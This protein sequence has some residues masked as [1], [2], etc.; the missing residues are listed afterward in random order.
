MA[1]INIG[2]ALVGRLG[3]A[4]ARTN[5]GRWTVHDA[6]QFAD[7]LIRDR[8]LEVKGLGIETLSCYLLNRSATCDTIVSCAALGCGKLDRV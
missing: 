6:L 7:V 5:R 4:I 3:R 2:A 8:F 1:S